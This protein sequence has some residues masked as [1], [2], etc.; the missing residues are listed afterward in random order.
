MRRI[1][2]FVLFLVTFPAF[3]QE[4]A[5]YKVYTKEGRKSSYAKIGKALAGKQAVFFGELHDDPVAHWLEL[6][7]LREL[8]AMHGKLLVCGSEMYER[9]NQGALDAYLTGKMN[10][11]EFADSCRLWPNQSTDYQPMLDYAKEHQLP[12]IATNIPR[13]YASQVF[14][15]GLASLDQLGTEDLR[16]ICPLPFDVDTTLSQ[17]RDLL[18][19]EMHMGPDFVY[20][21]AIKDATMGWSISQHLN[22]NS[23]FY[24][25]NG[26]YHSDFNQGILWYVNHYDKLPYEKMLTISLV[27]QEDIDRL[28]D[29][30]K[31]K[32]DFIICVPET[33]TRTH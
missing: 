11:K 7:I 12:W 30:F 2:L 33:M 14:K 3:G 6:E 13:R 25:V 27:T 31:G 24:H 20:A 5:A 4:M 1:L 22:E 18:D 29:E 19:G 10:E 9:D 26:S 32:A 16:W 28:D 15:K 8:Y 21:Q 23:V 17:Y